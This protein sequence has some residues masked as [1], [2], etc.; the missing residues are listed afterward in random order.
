MTP[1]F[2]PQAEIEFLEA[3]DY[4]EDRKE[5]LGHEFAV[6]VYPTVARIL[7]PPR[8]WPI[9]EGDIRRCQTGRFPYG[10]VYSEDEG[11]VF[12]LAIM[13]LHR[14]PDYWKPRQG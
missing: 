10:V 12:I 7:E 9:L 5:G 11:G 6:E 3:I 2:H 1:S 4:Y 8:A 13:H 14:D